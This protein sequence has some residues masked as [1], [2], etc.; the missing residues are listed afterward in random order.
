[1]K[2]PT[3]VHEIGHAIGFWHEHTRPDRDNYVEI[4]YDNIEEGY[5]KNFEKVDPSLIDS[6]G[7]GYDYN[8]IMHYNRDF[9]VK[10]NGLDTLRAKEDGIPVGQAVAL[11]PTDIEQ[12]N[13]LYAEQCGNLICITANSVAHTSCFPILGAM[14]A[15]PAEN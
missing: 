9:F 2:F 14:E 15:Q 4:L 12:T 8:S 10:Y 11:S 5:S 7:V 13:K 1:L 6:H 3:I